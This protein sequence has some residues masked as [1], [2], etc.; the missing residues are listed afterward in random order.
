MSENAYQFDIMNSIPC[1]FC[2]TL[3][4]LQDYEEHARECVR[5]TDPFFNFYNSLPNLI[6]RIAQNLQNTSEGDPDYQE[7]DEEGIGAEY[8]TNESIGHGI[9]S[10]EEQIEDN[11]QPFDANEEHYEFFNDQQESSNNPPF[12]ETSFNS[13]FM[14]IPSSVG[15]MIP[16]NV[17]AFLSNPLPVFMNSNPLHEDEGNPLIS[18]EQL[19]E[20]HL[21]GDQ[22]AENYNEFMNL[23]ER[24]GTVK[25]GFNEET[26]KEKFRVVEKTDVCCICTEEK[27]KFLVS[28]CNHEL[29]EECTMEWFKENKKCAH[30]QVEIE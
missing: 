23:A 21:S 3:I 14:Q 4:D 5:R 19:L 22:T 10:E 8:E 25:I 9:E 27:N 30:C 15:P 28:P 16:D 20:Q 6:D 29:C 17:Q 11:I 18:F 1:E 13:V 26:I 12:Q 24:I 7:V 2:Q